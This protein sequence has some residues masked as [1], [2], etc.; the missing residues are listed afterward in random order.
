MFFCNKCDRK[1]GRKDNLIR[2]HRKKHNDDASLR[3]LLRLPSNSV[4]PDD[5]KRSHKLETKSSKATDDYEEDMVSDEE[6][7]TDNESVVPAS[8]TTGD[9][10]SEQDDNSNA[11]E[12]VE[13]QLNDED[14]TTPS[15]FPLRN[16]WQ[17]IGEDAVREND[18]DVVCTY[19]DQV[20]L[21]RKLKDDPIHQKV[22]ETMESLQ[23]RDLNMDF[24][25]AL[26]KAATR[27]KHII[28]QAAAS[29]MEVD[30]D[31]NEENEEKW[32]LKW[33]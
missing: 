32:L 33:L 5:G 31:S 20:R 25:E 6:S 2:H 30:A 4:L 7:V 17:L 26:L 21:G 13:E 14:E 16:V 23:E 8:S 11:S 18:G 1:F 9:S 28:Q 10:E 24:D 22:L 15:L 27:R 19:I 3:S 12:D 29:V